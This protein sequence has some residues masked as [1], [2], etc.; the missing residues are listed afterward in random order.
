MDTTGRRP[1]VTLWETYGA[2]ME[3]VAAL[4]AERLGVEAHS[5]RFTPAEVAAAGRSGRIGEGDGEIWFLVGATGSSLRGYQRSE[6]L[7][8]VQERNERIAAQITADVR[9]EAERGGVFMGRAATHI[10]RD[11]PGALHV[12][13]DGPVRDR[14]ERAAAAQGIALEEAE[15]QE[16]WND[17]VR[18]QISIELFGWNPLDNSSYDMV[19][20]TSHMPAAT[21]ADLIAGAARAKAERPQP[22]EPTQQ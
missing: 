22:T 14:I 20:N 21:C 3:E 17:E 9:A 8:G 19:F 16:Q 15:E 7:R 18:S 10:L 6:L 4:V 13:L 12:Q 5:Q 1:V 2:G 11:W